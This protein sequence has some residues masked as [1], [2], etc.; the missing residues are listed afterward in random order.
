VIARLL[1]PERRA[2]ARALGAAIRLG[3]D[4]AGR[5]VEVLRH[6]ALG[7]DN[8]RLQLTAEP[9]WEDMLLGEQTAKRALTLAQALKIRFQMG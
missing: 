6:A 1:T 5:N 3:C 7:L 8:D 9:G 2:R 4:L